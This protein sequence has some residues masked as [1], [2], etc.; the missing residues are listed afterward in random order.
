MIITI[1]RKQFAMARNNPLLAFVVVAL[2]AFDVFVFRRDGNLLHGLCYIAAMW[3]CAYITDIWMQVFPPKASN[4]V[5]KKPT[6]EALIFLLFTALGVGFL[7]IRFM[8]FKDWNNAPKLY[9]LTALP[10]ILFVFPIALAAY[11]LIKKYSLKNL[12]LRFDKSIF[13]A[14]PIAAVTAITTW[15]VVPQNIHWTEMIK[16]EGIPQFLLEGFITAAL[17]EEFMRFIGQTRLGAFFNNIGWGWFATVAIW[18]LMHAPK[19][20]ADGN[21]DI[22][23]ALEG[24]ARIIPLGLMWSYMI[25]RTKSIMPSLLVHATNLWGLQNP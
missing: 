17:C 25:H 13:L 23:G 3:L 22:V 12:G 7:V 2:C 19:W 21:G 6:T 8:L 11:F 15:L 18:A 1:L 4:P 16:S 10:L 24:S 20:Y 14:L 5:V 9:K